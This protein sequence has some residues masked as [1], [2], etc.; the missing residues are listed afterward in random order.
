[1]N[2]SENPWGK[3]ILSSSYRYNH[4]YHY[5]FNV[6]RK[7]CCHSGNVSSCRAKKAVDIVEKQQMDYSDF[8]DEDTGQREGKSG[9]VQISYRKRRFFLE[10][11]LLGLSCWEIENFVPNQMDTGNTFPIFLPFFLSSS[12]TLIFLPFCS[13]YWQVL[14]SGLLHHPTDV[15]RCRWFVELPNILLD[16]VQSNGTLLS[17]YV[18]S[19]F[20]FIR[21]LHP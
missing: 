21:E 20:A 6:H 8:F 12:F 1:M 17:R 4:H 18:D 16:R 7:T 15:H 19:L 13:S 5:R 3:N 11:S 9:F 14:R 10:L 2:S